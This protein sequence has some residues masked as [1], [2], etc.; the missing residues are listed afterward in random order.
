MPVSDLS[1]R[2]ICKDPGMIFIPG[3]VKPLLTEHS[4]VYP[5]S[6][7]LNRNFRLAALFTQRMC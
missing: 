3:V 4:L 6:S 7:P 2:W 5:S 1:D